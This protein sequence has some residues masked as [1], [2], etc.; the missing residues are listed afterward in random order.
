[1]TW[2]LGTEVVTSV[3]YSSCSNLF[4]TLALRIWAIHK[5]NTFIF[6]KENLNWKPSYSKICWMALLYVLQLCNFQT[7][8]RIANIVLVYVTNNTASSR[9]PFNDVVPLRSSFAQIQ[10]I[11]FCLIS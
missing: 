4:Q 7:E 5:N 2:H 6:T 3:L 10:I 9:A 1:L 8:K 11:N